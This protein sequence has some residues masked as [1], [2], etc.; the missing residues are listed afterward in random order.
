[1]KITK[2]VVEAANHA[3]IVR[4]LDHALLAQGKKPGAPDRD[5][6]LWD[7]LLAGFGMRITGA[8]VKSYLVQYRDSQNRS[9]RVTIGRHGVLTA[10]TARSIAQQTL[11][12][13]ARGEN[14][15]EDKRQRKADAAAEPTIKDLSARY[16]S[17]WAEVRKKPKSLADD[18]QKLS[19]YI[20]PTFEGRAVASITREDVARLHH[21]LR[22]MPTQAN[23]TVALLSKMMNLAEVWGWR[24]DGSNPCRHIGRYKEKRRERFLSEREMQLIGQA[25]RQLEEPSATPVRVVQSIGRDGKQRTIHVKVAPVYPPAI[26][27]LRLLLLTGARLGEVLSLKWEYVDYEHSLLR[28]PD[29]KTGAK[30]IVLGPPAIKLLSEAKRKK[31]SPWVCPGERGPEHIR[32]LNGPW[33]R[34]KAKINELQ[35]KEEAEG[36]LEKKDRI[37]LATLRLH[38]LRHSFASVGAAGG[39]SLPTIGALLGHTQAATTQRYA[40]FAN[41]P[42]RQAAGIVAGHIAA[43]LDGKPAGEVVDMNKEGVR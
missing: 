18:K 36:K 40:H 15:A 8:G 14:P 23:R 16:L 30:V 32:D 25:L 41:D 13:V 3:E 19:K 6:F 21:K 7:E 10:E 20:E 26:L 1:M 37:D 29:S 38:D 34:L 9:H 4:Q 12:A 43:V 33:R 5:V 27:A 35:D 17:E 22:D 11:A 24:S 42:L 2:R 31:G 28:L 39:L